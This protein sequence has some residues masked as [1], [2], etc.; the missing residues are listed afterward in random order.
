MLEEANSCWLSK[1]CLDAYALLVIGVLMHDD[2]MLPET[3]TL[4]QII[5]HLTKK[6]DSI[7]QPAFVSI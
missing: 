6:V 3:I 4:N 2:K 1:R 7:L 5:D